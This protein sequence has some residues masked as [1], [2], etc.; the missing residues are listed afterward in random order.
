MNMVMYK[1]WHYLVEASEVD[2]CIMPNVY[3]FSEEDLKR[4]ISKYDS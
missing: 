3:L 2:L 1:A 4:I